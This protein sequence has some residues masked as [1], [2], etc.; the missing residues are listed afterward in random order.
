VA[1]QLAGT[2]IRLAMGTATTQEER[3][4]SSR[5]VER[6]SWILCNSEIT[7]PG[8]NKT[9]AIES[10]LVGIIPMSCT[11]DEMKVI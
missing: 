5:R 8:K 2:G 4:N 6:R 9:R 1:A 3:H 10:V 11:R 7:I